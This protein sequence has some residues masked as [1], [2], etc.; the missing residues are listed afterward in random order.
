MHP[1][2]IITTAVAAGAAGQPGVTTAVVLDA[3]GELR[4][5]IGQRYPGVDLRDIAAEPDSATARA[6]LNAAFVANHADVDSELLYAAQQ[7]V[8]TALGN[9]A[10][11]RTTATLYEVLLAGAEQT[12]GP[13]N[14]DTLMIRHELAQ[15]YHS[16]GDIDSA[17]THFAATLAARERVLGADDTLTITTRTCLANCYRDV[18][19][20]DDAIPL[21]AAVLTARERYF[22]PAHDNPVGYRDFLADA[23]ESADRFD[24]AIELR[25]TNLRLRRRELGADHPDTLGTQLSLA[26]AYGFAGRIEQAVTA[27]ETA[28]TE[29]ER[30]VGAAQEQTI[31]IRYTL[32]RGY[33]AAGRFDESIALHIKVIEEY[34]RVVGPDHADLLAMRNSLAGVYEDAGRLDDAIATY[35]RVLADSERVYGVEHE[36]TDQV[37]TWLAHLTRASDGG[38]APV[39]A[40]GDLDELTQR[41][42]NRLVDLVGETGWRRIDLIARAS[43]RVHDLSLTVL[44]DHGAAT[45]LAAPTEL[46]PL[47]DAIKIAHYRRDPERGGWLSARFL[48][49]SS[50]SFFRSYDIDYEPDWPFA[51]DEATY[52][53]ELERF[54]RELEY[55]PEWLLDRLPKW[56]G[57]AKNTDTD[58]DITELIPLNM[59]LVAQVLDSYRDHLLHRLPSDW[60]QLFIDFRSVGEYVETRAQVLTV[61]GQAIEWQAPQAQTFFSELRRDMYRP[62][63]G[64]WTS[65]RFHLV[66][67]GKYHAEYD[68]E[69][70]PDWDH[71]PDARAYQQELQMFPRSAEHVPGWLDARQR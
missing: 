9:P 46:T 38:A 8:D 29:H 48:I 11:D 1:I 27:Y 68:W 63:Q 25:E 5:L 6:T 13:D 71:R 40:G 19:R 64:T 15:A 69:H 35:T 2:D 47:L 43:G 57:R 36:L 53:E 66:V 51:I 37:R 3:Y 60:Q 20:V 52:V 62:W 42:G 56:Q 65:V 32:A 14:P 10:A 41:L 49:D 33:R 12:Q 24:R 17:I 55:T 26:C 21:D 61:L 34:V 23:Y 50:G 67:N 4:N 7:F 54:P 45:V 16:I 31:L 30:V 58:T 59:Q 28:L 44:P 22:G 18:G 39:D 70:E